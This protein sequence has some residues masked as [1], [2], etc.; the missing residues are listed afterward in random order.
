MGR[1]LSGQNT[2]SAVMAQRREAKDSLDYFAT[3]PWAT[4]A[5]TELLRRQGEAMHLMSV[6]DPAC[7]EGYM[8]RPLAEAFG[9]VVATDV[10]DYRAAWHGQDGVDDI[11]LRGAP[12]TVG[13]VPILG[14]DWIITNPPFRLAHQFID[15][16]IPLARSGVAML[17]RSTFTEGAEQ[18]RKL[19]SKTPPTDILQFVERVVM[20][21][22]RPQDP[23]I[24]V[25][26]PKTGKLRKPSSATAYCWLVWQ[27]PLP[28][29]AGPPAYGW[30]APCRTRLERPGDYDAPVGLSEW[31]NGG[32]HAA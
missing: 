26:H 9:Q 15:R 10:H 22:G 4:R 18:Y 11:L 25:P 19:F 17:V 21:K 5:L 27:K 29:F 20:T 32:R 3:P 13:D 28:E 7:G 23:N 8:A 14:A 12:Q 31:M 16:A 2:S 1:Q 30:I 6:W 24:A